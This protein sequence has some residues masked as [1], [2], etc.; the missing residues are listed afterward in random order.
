MFSSQL[1]AD[2]RAGVACFV[3]QVDADSVDAVLLQLGEGD[4]SPVDEADIAVFVGEVVALVFVVDVVKEADADAV[5]RIVEVG[6]GAVADLFFAVFVAK[7]GVV[8]V[9]RAVKQQDFCTA[10]RSEGGDFGGRGAG[11]EI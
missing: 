1:F 11:G 5:K 9:F 10:V 7:H 2:Q 6:Q 3:D 8:A 4:D